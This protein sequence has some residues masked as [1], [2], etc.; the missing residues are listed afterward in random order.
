MATPI[1]ENEAVFSAEE[2]R[3]VANMIRRCGDV[4]GV[5]VDSRAVREGNLFVALRGDKHDAHA[6]VP[7]AIAQ[8]ARALLVDRDVEAPE[9]VGVFR[10]D[11]TLVALGALGALHRRRFEIPLIAITGSV[12][13]TTTKELTRAAL[14]GAGRHTMATRGNLNNRV[15]VP[16]TLLTLS[17]EHDAAVIEMGMNVPGEI[18]DLCTIA[19]PT[20]GAVTSIAEVHTEGVGGI[21]GVAREKGALFEGL[22]ADAVAIFNADEPRLTPYLERSAAARKIGFGTGKAQVQLVS[23]SIDAGAKTRASY[24]VGEKN[25]ELTLGLL[26]GAAAIDAACALAIVHAI[27]PDDAAKLDAAAQ[28][29]ANL[30]PGEHRMTPIALANGALVIDDAYNASPRAVKAAIETSAALA[31]ARNGALIVALGDMLELGRDAERLHAEVGKEAAR[32]GAKAVIVC[33]EL[34]AHAGRA[35]LQVTMES[36]AGARAKIVILRNVDDAA[37]CVREL[38]G[39]RDVVLVKG[40]RGMRME[41]V[42]DALTHDP[43]SA[44]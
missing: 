7:Q 14:E 11:D 19:R 16:M 23:W 6:F 33:G 25:I 22:G 37:E 1:P 15:G 35:A 36:K 12:G 41:R 32:A 2:L 17:A 20:I 39:S 27:E 43:G 4:R 30:A 8:G 29:I 5:A 44:S 40:S 18:A 42:V 10:A 31:K 24:A 3:A 38:M 26:G 13:K 28:A 9:H 21:D 34:M